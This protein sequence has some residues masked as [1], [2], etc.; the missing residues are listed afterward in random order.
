LFYLG[1]DIGKRNHEAGL[2]DEKGNPI[3]KTLRF[4]NSKAGSDKLLA[5]FN[6]HDLIP[7]NTVIGLE[8]TGHYWLSIFSFIHK[9]GFKTTVFNPLQSDALRHFYIRKTK[10]DT[11]DAYLIAQVIR[12]DSP[13]ETPFIEEDLLRLRHLERLRYAFVDQSSD[14]K[15][16]VIS[17]L[18][19]VF[20]EYERLFSDVFGKSSTE[21]LLHTPLPEDLLDIDTDT[22][23]SLLNQVSKG[24]FGESRA[25][26]KANQLHDRALNTFGINIATD[27][28]KLQIKLLLEQIH[29]I[30]QHLKQ[31]EQAMIEISNRQEHYLTT[32]TE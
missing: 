7:D 30:E 31:I 22:L 6:Q 20:P 23:A 12:I 14:L 11:K 21:I 16:K 8:A 24:R 10:T 4:A 5:F 18:D 13:D 28:F 17:L 15:R 1:I 26:D 3:G 2:I 25:L 19:Q 29:L 32:I 9:L 27:V